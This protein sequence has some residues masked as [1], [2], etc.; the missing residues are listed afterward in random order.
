MK[1]K[2]LFLLLFAG[3]IISHAQITAV[4]IVGEAAGGWPM[5]NP[6]EIDLHQ[7]TTSDGENWTVNGLTLANAVSGGGLKF[8]ANNAWDLNWGTDSFPSGI[9][10]QGGA[11]IICYAGTYDVTFNSTT[12]A[13]SFVGGTPPPTVKLIGATVDNPLGLT[14]STNNGTLYTLTNISLITGNA[15]FEIDGVIVG[16]DTFPTGILTGAANNIPVVG[17]SY[18]SVS[19]N[20][21]TGEYGFIFTPINPN[22]EVTISGSAIGGSSNNVTMI[23]ND[24]VSY[25]YNNLS[26][27]QGELFFNITS[28]SATYGDANFPAGT[29]TL[30]GEAILVPS[31]TWTVTFNAISKAYSFNGNPEN[32]SISIVGSAVGGWPT[33]APGEIDSQQ[34]NTTDGITYSIT[35]LVCNVGSAKFRQNNEWTL[36]WGSVDFPTGNGTQGGNDIVIVLAGTYDVIFNRITG[37]YNFINSTP[38]PFTKLIGTATGSSEGLVM[39]SISEDLFQIEN[40]N[41]IDGSAQFYVDGT[42]FG[43]TQ[44]PT[45]TLTGASNVIPVPA[46]FYTSV[47]LNIATGEYSFE[48]APTIAIVGTGAGGWPTGAPGE[49]DA[50]RLETTDGINFRLTGITLTDGEVKFRQ[51]NSWDVFWGGTSLTGTLVLNGPSIP[52]IAG[53][54]TISMNRDTGDYSL[55]SGSFKKSF[56]KVYPNPAQNIL[57]VVSDSNTVIVS[58][59]IFDTLGKKVIATKPNTTSIGLDISEINPGL[60]FAKI[61]TATGFETIKLMKN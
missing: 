26:T 24:G 11:N 60:Y 28:V 22:S 33:G 21:V 37:E 42:I 36:N 5:G 46:G 54:Y 41:L 39:T 35:N 51:N 15:Q 10:L 29:A 17:A 4:S 49:I 7:M 57:N 9:G 8:R 53:T 19:V 1:H 58:I 52:T 6:G 3:F 48:S 31:G 14:M 12:G 23:T 56:F 47:T 13:Y 43:E 20:I 45:G 16:E 50:N 61:A 44:F 32:P 30:N 34:M 55:S 38:F 27:T 2:L 18:A 40:I 59:D 25:V